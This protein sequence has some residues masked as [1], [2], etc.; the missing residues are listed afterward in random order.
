[1]EY[2]FG[3]FSGGYDREGLRL[4]TCQA[5]ETRQKKKRAPFPAGG[6]GALT[7]VCR[8][9]SGRGREKLILDVERLPVYDKKRAGQDAPGRKSLAC[10]EERKMKAL[11]AM[12]LAMLLAP[13]IIFLGSMVQLL[14]NRMDPRYRADRYERRK[15]RR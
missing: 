1:L 7:A 8:A 2:F 3:C 11:L 6:K 13:A 15:K 10:G 9:F 14:N 4:F 5:S 12:L